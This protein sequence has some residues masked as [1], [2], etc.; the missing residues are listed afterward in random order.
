MRRIVQGLVSRVR[1]RPRPGANELFCARSTWQASVGRRANR[2]G[3]LERRSWV[4]RHGAVDVLNTARAQYTHLSAEKDPFNGRD[5]E[6]CKHG[7][8]RYAHARAELEKCF[9]RLWRK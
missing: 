8:R 9:L 5:L 7:T 4:Q 3:K 2:A 1:K 6:L